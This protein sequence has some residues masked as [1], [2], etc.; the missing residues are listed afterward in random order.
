MLDFSNYFLIFSVFF[1]GIILL[2]CGKPYPDLEM[3]SLNQRIEI[4]EQRIEK[5][6]FIINK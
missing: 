3:K 2:L 1:A 6:E 5:I 4:L